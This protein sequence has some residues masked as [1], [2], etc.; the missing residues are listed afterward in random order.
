MKEITTYDFFGPMELTE[1]EI[2]W[3]HSIVEKCKAATGCTVDII[4][5]DHDLYSGKSKN[6]LGCCITTDQE[7]PLNGDSYI[8]IDTWFIHEKYQVEFDN[9]PAIEKAT[10]EDTIAHEIAHLYCWRH[11]KKH[12]RITAELLEKIQNAA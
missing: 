8:T 9:F 4:A 10:I 1:A 7:N 12:N 5:Y 11:G 3:F 6:A 2:G